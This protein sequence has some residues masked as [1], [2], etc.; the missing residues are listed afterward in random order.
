M[1]AELELTSPIPSDLGKQGTLTRLLTRRALRASDHKR[2]QAA[3]GTRN[4]ALTSNGH[5]KAART[6]GRTVLHRSRLRILGHKTERSVAPVTSVTP[7]ADPEPAEDPNPE[8]ADTTTTIPEPVADPDT[9]EDPNPEPADTAT[10]IPEPAADPEA[11]EDPDTEP[12]RH[13]H[14]G[15]GGRSAARRS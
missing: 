10:T 6:P 3:S 1:P 2:P 7:V 13:H 8:P 12:A 11:A 4:S 15:S 5:D 9:A 14:P